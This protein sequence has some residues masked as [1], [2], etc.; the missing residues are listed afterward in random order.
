MI[1]FLSYLLA[2][3][4]LLVVPNAVA[5]EPSALMMVFIPGLVFLAIGSLAV[6]YALTT[7]IQHYWLQLGL[8]IFSVA[9]VLTPTPISG[10]GFWWPN[11]IGLFFNEHVSVTNA[12]LHASII[13]LVILFL[14]W[15]IKKQPKV[16]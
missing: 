11:A 13:T 12:L 7:T 9:I 16:K 1:R 3:A 10:A 2:V 14:W 5:S 15:I 4:L 6:C 8:R